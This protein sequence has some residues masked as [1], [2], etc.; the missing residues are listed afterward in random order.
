METHRATAQETH[1]DAGL[2]S[3][4]SGPPLLLSSSFSDDCRSRGEGGAAAGEGRSGGGGGGAES[5]VGGVRGEAA[6]DRRFWSRAA[7]TAV[8]S[9]TED[10]MISNI[11][12]LQAVRLRGSVGMA[13]TSSGACER[14]R[15]RL[16]CSGCLDATSAVAR[17]CSASHP[18][19]P[20]G[21]A[22]VGRCFGRCPARRMIS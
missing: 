9:P 4:N 1:A 2:I 7:S 15:I 11:A 21:G 5:D 6:C 18:S 10:R 22:I 20:R 19:M 16:S 13:A 12:F 14:V 3:C 8:V 17:P